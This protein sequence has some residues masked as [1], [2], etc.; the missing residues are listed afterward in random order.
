MCA[1]GFTIFIYLFFFFCSF[2]V[3]EH[4]HSHP[5][6]YNMLTGIQIHVHRSIW[7]SGRVFSVPDCMFSM[8][9]AVDACSS[10][11]T[12][13][14]CIIIRIFFFRFNFLPFHH[15][16]DVCFFRCCLLYGIQCAVHLNFGSC[17]FGFC[18][19]RLGL[20][21][22]YLYVIL[23]TCWVFFVLCRRNVEQFFGNDT[24]QTQNKVK[25]EE[26]GTRTQM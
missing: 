11:F 4:E 10:N 8:E 9:S 7:Y 16:V 2:S 12:T 26:N 17:W 20:F 21:L 3:D 5:K 6:Q 25:Y 15:I 22:F 1:F 18:C 19:T 24:Q 23:C 14:C 13:K